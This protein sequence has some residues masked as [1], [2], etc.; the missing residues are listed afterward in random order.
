M[1]YDVLFL[2]A[3]DPVLPSEVTEVVSAVRTLASELSRT[4]APDGGIRTQALVETLTPSLLV[5]GVTPGFS[6]SF[7]TA[8]VE[9]SSVDRRVAVS[10][11]TGRAATNN[12]A[13]LAVLAAA[14]SP[15]VQWAIIVLPERYKGN[16]TYAAV[17]RQLGE[18]RAARGIHLDL[19]GVVLVSF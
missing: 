1:A 12:D 13:L 15:D 11:R 10:V 3:T 8:Q 18:L 5:L 16:Q 2:G 19:R 9:L 14:S 4:V 17:L 7:A 6:G